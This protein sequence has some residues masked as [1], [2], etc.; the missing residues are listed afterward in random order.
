[1]VFQ[2]HLFQTTDM[3]ESRDYI[4]SNTGTEEFELDK[5]ACFS[6]FRHNNAVIGCSSMNA[7][8]WNCRESFV[9]K[10]VEKS[11][12]YSFHFVTAGRCDVGQGR[13]QFTAKAGDVYVLHP[14]QQAQEHW[15]GDCQQLILR[16]KTDEIAAATT[17]IL[18]HQLDDNLQFTALAADPGIAAWLHS[19]PQLRNDGGGEAASLFDDL[20]VAYHFEQS[21]IM[22]LL[23]GLSHSS[24]FDMARSRTTPAPYYV[25]RVETYFR[26]NFANDITMDDIV[27]ASGVS[28]RTVFYGFKRWR[29]TSPMGLLRDLRL[30]KAQALLSQGQAGPRSVGAA[31]I[32]VGLTNLSQFSKLYKARFGKNPSAALLEVPH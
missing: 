9:V 2:S 6:N 7:L 3:S 30:D 20:R 22:M 10:K 31:A 15:I 24:S 12:N 27:I 17:K 26:E 23:S 29:G 19:L 13:D 11:S 21:L 16:I 8:Q 4:L 25:K 14:A 5:R 1:M 18:G 32:A 28:V